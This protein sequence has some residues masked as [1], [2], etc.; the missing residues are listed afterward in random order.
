MIDEAS[1]LVEAKWGFGYLSF[2]CLSMGIDVEGSNSKFG[3]KTWNVGNSSSRL[4]L[5]FASI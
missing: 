3:F 5:F 4:S 1:Y 2:L